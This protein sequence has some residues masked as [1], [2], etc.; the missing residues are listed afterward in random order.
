M[1][2]GSLGRRIRAGLALA[3]FVWGAAS[4]QNPPEKVTPDLIRAGEKNYSLNCAPCHGTRM[5]E[6]PT[7]VDLRKFPRDQ[8]AR[9]IN[10]VSNGRNTMPPWRGALSP[11]E[12]EA[13]WA[14]VSAGELN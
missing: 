5:L 8:R 9:F 10:V 4:A 6:P 7:N 13:L 12:I 11:E 2:N 14:Y 1:I 3:C